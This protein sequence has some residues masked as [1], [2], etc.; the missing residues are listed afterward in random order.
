MDT[1]TSEVP[2]RGY[3]DDERSAAVALVAANAG[4]VNATATELGIPET[5][6]RQW[7]NGD[8]CAHLLPM[9][10]QKR[11][12]LANRIRGVVSRM[13]DVLEADIS[14]IKPSQ[15][16]V[17][18]GIGIDKILA[19]EGYGRSDGTTVNVNVNAPSVTLTADDIAAARRLIEGGSGRVVAEPNGPIGER[20]GSEEAFRANR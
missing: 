17:I 2:Y 8:R 19:L 18:M 20:E 14:D 5:T 12:N 4:N 1:T 7:V 11:R 15:A 16:A 3:S 13:I 10:E 9:S 6:L